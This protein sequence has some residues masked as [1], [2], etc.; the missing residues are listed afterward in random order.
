[1][2]LP[3]WLSEHPGPIAFMHID[4]DLYSSTKTIFDLVDERIQAGTII[5]FDEYF[6]YTNWRRHEYKAFQEYV[7]QKGVTYE[8]LGYARQQVLIRI[9]EIRGNTDPVVAPLVEQSTVPTEAVTL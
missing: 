3:P 7:G 9:K 2:S 6:N 4:C 5:L 8:Y 1:M